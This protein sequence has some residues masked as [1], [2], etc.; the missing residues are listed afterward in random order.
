MS[1]AIPG[2]T[3]IGA[4]P[5]HRSSVDL[6]GVPSS[7]VKVMRDQSEEIGVQVVVAGRGDAPRVEVDADKIAWVVTTLVGNALRY[8]RRG[9][10]RTPG[11]TVLVEL[12]VTPVAATITV[13]DDGPGIPP[14]KL[15]AI[16]EQSGEARHGVGLNLLLVRDVVAAHGGEVEITSR[17]S[18]IDGGTKVRLRIPRAPADS[19]L[20][21]GEAASGTPAGSRAS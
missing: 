4:I 16:F 10:R 12:D 2:P 8:V 13:D 15:A 19:G 21:G 6:L 1:T 5:L 11:G 14:E 17:C 20:A 18:A 9:T 7:A 3:S